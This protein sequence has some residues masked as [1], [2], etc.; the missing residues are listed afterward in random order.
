MSLTPK[1]LS[2]AA[3]LCPYAL[4]GV[5]DELLGDILDAWLSDQFASEDHVHIH[6]W[7]DDAEVVR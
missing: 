6:G 7:S 4:T 3:S 2:V 1:T 5:S